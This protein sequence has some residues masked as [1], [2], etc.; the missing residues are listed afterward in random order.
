MIR[1]RLNQGR[2]NN[3]R[4]VGIGTDFDSEWRRFSSMVSNEMFRIPKQ[5]G[6]DEPNGFGKDKR[7]N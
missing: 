2:K 7:S 5:D 6:G 1:N 3:F 4:Q